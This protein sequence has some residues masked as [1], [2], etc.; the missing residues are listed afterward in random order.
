[1]ACPHAVPLIEPVP[2]GVMITVYWKRQAPPFHFTPPVACHTKSA[3]CTS[4]TNAVLNTNSRD[5]SPFTER[6]FVPART[7]HPCGVRLSVP[8]TV[9]VPASFVLSVIDSVPT[10][11]PPFEHC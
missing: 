5:G 3:L 8:L 11:R 9:P 7:T 1:M 4:R 6:R 2:R 10:M